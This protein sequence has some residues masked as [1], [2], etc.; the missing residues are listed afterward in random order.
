[1]TQSKP[2]SKTELKIKS[3][4][5]Q[6]PQRS[7]MKKPASQL[8]IFRSRLVLAFALGSIGAFLAML[9]FAAS[10]P[11]YPG[12]PHVPVFSAP[13]SAPFARPD[14]GNWSVVP[15]P[16]ALGEATNN[17]FGI[18]CITASDCWAVGYALPRGGVARTLIEHWDGS[19]W[20]IVDSTNTGDAENNYLSGVACVSASDCWAVGEYLIIEGGIPTD[21]TL[22]QHWDG[23]SW[24]IVSSPNVTSP[25]NFLYGVSCTSTSNCW[26]VGYYNGASADQTLI[27]HWDG[28]S[29][30]IVNSPNTLDTQYNYLNDVTC[31]SVFDC[32]AVGSYSGTFTQQTL[33]ARWDGASW[34]IV[35]SPNTSATQTNYLS[36]VTCTSVSDCSAVG[37]FLTDDGVYQTLIERWDGLS[38]AIVDSPNTGLTSD[39]FLNAVTCS[40]PS[41]CWA[42][43]TG[44]IDGVYLTLI[45]RWDGT[46][47]TIV[48]APNPAGTQ[49][50][51]LEAVTCVSDSNCWA[52]GEY[53]TD[54][55]AYRTLIEHYAEPTSTPTPTPTPT[56]PPRVTPRPRPTPAPR[57][58]PP[59]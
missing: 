45:E 27:E 2:L 57:P 47:W 53:L 31:T 48:T 28:T 50:A 19:S 34:S 42:V 26:A 43:G 23:S 16:N 51:S 12:M 36:G 6:Q 49:G 10:R 44:K 37:Q 7:K 13:R 55:F 8:G 35:S 58:T 40:S 11:E 54:T 38:W 59:R 25:V 5:F 1:M 32:W 4:M 29:W 46:S 17:L 9:S 56:A 21:K 30:A 14:V 33:I 24:S 39:N 22:I 41:D 15:S 20:T 18:V 52:V 3:P